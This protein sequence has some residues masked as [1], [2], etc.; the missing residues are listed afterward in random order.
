M[1]RLV[2]SACIATV[3][4]G[5]P[6][7][8]METATR[9]AWGSQAHLRTALSSPS[10]GA[11]AQ[12]AGRSSRWRSVSRGN[13]E[14]DGIACPGLRVCYAFGGTGHSAA[15]WRTTIVATKDAGKTW[16]TMV[17]QPAA[18]PLFHIA[19]PS[20]QACYAVGIIE[21]EGTSPPPGVSN[22]VV[23]TRD[24]GHT[25]Q[26][27]FTS[28]MA[29]IRSGAC[30]AGRLD[31]VYVGNISCPTVS[32]CFAPG[33][34]PPPKDGTRPTSSVLLTTTNG[35]R[36]WRQ[37][38]IHVLS[39][40]AAIACPAVTTCYMVGPVNAVTTD[41]GVT[42]RT[43]PGG[44]P[45]FVSM[46][47]CPAVQVCYTVG[48]RS[49]TKT[50]TDAGTISVTRNGGKTWHAFYYRDASPYGI[51]CPTARICYAAAG[52][53]GRSSASILLTLDG[54]N[55][56]QREK[57]SFGAVDSARAIACPGPDTCYAVSGRGRIYRRT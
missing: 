22:D 10:S 13:R 5:W 46:I 42:W 38:A 41:G 43:R 32:I 34:G 16:R 29:R 33:L 36:S 49:P 19:C 53:L 17:I 40:S 44:P 20:V 52:P 23:A 1:R 28:N 55:S 4:L 48:F 24:G 11:R 8:L 57:P 30:R 35:G 47:T 45:G 21:T 18:I 2:V 27:V 3:I 39:N 14:L 7:R 37:H 26:T 31:C 12:S 6:S 15:T 50:A 9:P 25:W 54:G 51:S 56:W